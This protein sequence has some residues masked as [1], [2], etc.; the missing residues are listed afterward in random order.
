MEEKPPTRGPPSTPSL[1][2]AVCVYLQDFHLKPAVGRGAVGDLEGLDKGLCELLHHREDQ[3]LGGT[4]GR[5]T[6]VGT[7]HT[8]IRALGA[9]VYP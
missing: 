3:H 4:L 8:L 9:Q 7:G 6:R 1:S 2:T 5:G